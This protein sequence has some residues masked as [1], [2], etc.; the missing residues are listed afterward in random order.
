MRLTAEPVRIAEHVWTFSGHGGSA[1]SP[2]DR[3]VIFRQAA[4]QITELWWL[5]R[6]GRRLG[7]LSD[8]GEYV[9]MTL[10]P[11]D[12]RVAIERL[13]TNGN[14]VIWVHEI[15]RSATARFSFDPSWNWSP[16]WSPDGSRIAFAA[17]PDG[18][19]ASISNRRAEP[20][21]RKRSSPETC[22][23]FRTTFRR[24]ASG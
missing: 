22:S 21:N 12:R 1:F 2:S 4:K 3:S 23:V 24:T 20:P 19:Q 7:S 18:K 8:P 13:D 17:A 11:D 5:D 16:I 9:H 14:G 15:D 6:N 10:S